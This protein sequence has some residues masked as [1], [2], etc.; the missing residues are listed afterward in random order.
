[1]GGIYTNK[2]PAQKI[3]T[4]EKFRVTI[5]RLFSVTI[6]RLFSVL[7]A[8]AFGGII[9]IQNSIVYYYAHNHDT[10]FFFGGYMK[11]S[12]LLTKIMLSLVLVALVFSLVACGNKKD[13][14]KGTTPVVEEKTLAEQVVEIIQG[15][16]PVLKVFNDT[17]SDGTLGADLSLSVKYNISGNSNDLALAV[18]ANANVDNPAAQ[19]SFKQKNTEWFNLTLNDKKVYLVQ[20]LTAVNTANNTDGISADIT[21]LVPA[22]TDIMEM[23]M[24]VIGEEEI[25]LPEDLATSVGGMLDKMGS[26]IT[27]LI[28]IETVSN[29]YKLVLGSEIMG[30]LK[31]M[32]PTILGGTL[33][34]LVGKSV[35][36]KV[37]AT[38]Q[39]FLGK[40]PE[41]SIEVGLKNKAISGLAIGYTL[42]TDTASLNLDFSLSNERVSI[43]NPTVGNNALNIGA[44]AE[45][46]Q[47]GLK[48]EA[49]VYGVPDF[50]KDLQNLVFATAKINNAVSNGYFN[51][52]TVYFDT[53]AVYEGLGQSAPDN[54]KYN[55]TIGNIDKDYKKT[56][57]SV[58]KMINEAA[59]KANK[60]YFDEKGT[61]SNASYADDSTTAAPSKSL[62]QTVYEMLGGKL[63]YTD[64]EKTAYKDVSEKDVM[65]KL[66]ELIG[67]YIRFELDT[68]SSKDNY[69]N[70]VK[71]ILTLFGQNDQWIIG[72]DLI[73]GTGTT[74]DLSGLTKMDELISF[75][76]W[77]NMENGK[78][79]VPD[80]MNG[81]FGIFNWDTKT[82]RGGV[83]LSKADAQNDLLDAINV[84]VTTG[85]NEDGT[86]KDVDAEFLAEFADYYVAALGYY[87]GEYDE[88]TTK[89]IDAI[90][91]KYAYA[92]FQYAN[93]DITKEALNEAKKEHKNSLKVYYTTA[94]ANDLIGKILGV[95]YTGD[96][97]YI[98]QLIDG[99][100]Y[101]YLGS[102]KDKGI[103]GFIEIKDSVEGTKSYAYLSGHINVVAND[104][105]AKITAAGI[106]TEDYATDLF[107]PAKVTATDTDA[108]EYAKI[109]TVDGTNV[110]QVTM[111]NDGTYKYTQLVV[112]NEVQYNDRYT[113]LDDMFESLGGAIMSYFGFN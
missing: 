36:D 25:N 78:I 82:Y 113:A 17:K 29:G 74:V 35:S 8:T 16:N 65:T 64:N 28:K 97:S 68:T 86:Y 59:E 30:L 48:A 37:I 33:T 106:K 81:V 4:A 83:T 112:N 1:M 21:A 75:D 62:N 31:T 96:T 77:I 110:K 49:E 71:N 40:N 24:D 61:A 6:G 101:L 22:V 52:Q 67:D 89:E 42:G 90:D 92:K 93:G 72:Y 69:F 27:N 53:N 20:P 9:K 66:N 76:K 55:V 111:E 58:V 99:G 2:F 56:N 70:T 26:G 87:V 5:G 109:V 108:N 41:L 100:L 88:A 13:D 7:T 15:V 63:E 45:L 57:S 43:T 79:K 38:A 85:K 98:A 3:V 104:V 94:K 19:I 54:T 44:V 84:F 105:N 80:N 91:M 107:T 11:K 12:S 51:G 73:K 102:D 95:S 46:A 47:K 23:A 14:N 60:K 39:E 34:N 50:S 18:K 10:H 103:N 32:L